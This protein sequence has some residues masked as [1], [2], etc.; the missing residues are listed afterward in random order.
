[1]VERLTWKKLAWE[2]AFFYT[3]WVIVGWIFGYMPWLLLAATALQLVWHL[4]NQVRLSS[5]LWDE[6]RL[7]PPSGSGNWESLFNGLYRLQQRQRR[8]RKELTNLIRRFRNGA[9]SL[10]DAVVVFRAEGNIVWC[11]RLAQ[12]LLGFH[13]PEDSGQPIS[14]LIRTP[15]FIKYLNK[16]D[17]SEPLEMRSQLNVER[18]LELRIVPYTEG[19]H[20]MVV[21][22]VS[23]LKQLEGMRRNFFANVSHELRTPMTVLQGY[24]E[25]TEDPDMIVG[26]MWTKAHGVM[27]EQLNR[28]N[29]LVNQLLTLSKIEA[30][31]MH[32]LEDVV[33]VPA[34]LEVLEKEAISLSGDDQHKLKFDVDTSLRVLGDDDQLRSAI[35]N[36]VYNAVKYTPPGANIHVRW[37]QTAQGACLEV[38]DSGDGIEPQHLHRLTERFYRVD[39][40]RSRDTGGSGLGLAIVKHALSHHDSHLE[41]Q[42]E[43]GVGSKFSFVLP[44]RLV[45]K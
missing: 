44:S 22:D 26:P 4:H 16:K 35:S 3:P 42:S 12:H 38:E 29:S 8:K 13:W 7:T 37:Y 39:K 14:N 23:Q 45:V 27:T 15:D 40:A 6:K 9:E 33:N 5:W 10:P 19:E 43:V 11:N 30:A 25:M 20:L 1:M 17:F 24:L 18:M 41:I 31:P 28:M 32:E 2:L 21:R 34:M 36:L